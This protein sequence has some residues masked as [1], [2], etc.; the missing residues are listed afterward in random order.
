MIEEAA[1]EST[2]QE[3]LSSAVAGYCDRQGEDGGWGEDMFPGA[4]SAIVNTVEIL[5]VLRAGGIPYEH[6]VVQKAMGYLCRAVVD[7]P[8]PERP[9]GLSGAPGVVPGRERRGEYTRYC[10]W[11]ISGLTLYKE[12]RHHERLEEAQLHCVRWLWDHMW[13]DV[14]PYAHAKQEGLKIKRVG[15][16]GET[17]GDEEPSLVS[18]SAAISGLSRMCP[19]QRKTGEAP[20]MLIRRARNTIHTQAHRHADADTMAFW[21]PP[22]G[23]EASEG[24]ASLTAMAVISLAGGDPQDRSCAADGARWLVS[25]KERWHERVESHPNV[26][27]TNWQHM[28]FSLALRAILRGAKLPSNDPILTPVVAHLNGLWREEDREWAHGLSQ[29]R[30][31]PSGSYAVV[32]AYEAMA[33]AWP[34]DAQ[35]QILE[36]TAASRRSTR[37]HKLEVRVDTTGMFVVSP[38]DG[39]EVR[40]E[41]APRLADVAFVVA[42][43]GELDGGLGSTSMAVHELAA[44]FEK[45]PE[46]IKHYARQI[47]N[48]VKEASLRWGTSIGEIVQITSDTKRRSKRVRINVETVVAVRDLNAIDKQDGI[49][50][51][52]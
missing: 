15:A 29:L 11:G 3:R 50:E 42:S 1:R 9:E 32:A 22:G 36:A 25:H 4:P 52:S 47:S 37:P 26:P 13:T 8:R 10:A 43:E 40:V 45:D 51:A 23:D 31:S 6:S 41:L 18:T 46:T 27:A 28:T 7:H 44:R 16:W 49:L 19:R 39:S 35:R 2:F 17:P 14:G 12:S 33:N 20:T 5:A 24:T 21:P 38:K 48:E 30:A 34:F